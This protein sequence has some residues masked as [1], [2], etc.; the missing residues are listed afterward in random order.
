VVRSFYAHSTSFCLRPHMRGRI[1]P[2]L[3]GAI[4]AAGEIILLS[5]MNSRAMALPHPA[6]AHANDICLGACGTAT[7]P[8]AKISYEWIMCILG[9]HT[10]FT[11]CCRSP[12]PG[13]HTTGEIPWRPMVLWMV[14]CRVS[15]VPNSPPGTTTEPP[16][17]HCQNFLQILL[18]K[19]FSSFPLSG[20]RD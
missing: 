15:A 14:V 9:A 4:P 1:L 18:L 17:C 2:L 16:C 6:S 5:H 7:C 10:A 13:Y 3:P 12:R 11:V 20:R 19:E 8:N